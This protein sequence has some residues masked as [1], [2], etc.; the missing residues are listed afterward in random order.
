MGDLAIA[1]S[2]PKILW[3]G[4]GEEDSRNSVAPGY[5][6]YKS[7]DGGL[8]WQSMGLEKTQHIGRIVI[9]PTNPD[10]VWCPRWAPSGAPTPSAVSTRRRW[11]QNLDAEQVHQRQSRVRR[12]RHGSARPDVLYA[13][14]WE[15]IR[16]PALSQS[17]GPGS[18]LWKTTDGGATWTEIKGGGFPSETMKGR[19]SWPSR[20]APRT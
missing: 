8:T 20:P 18:A 16:K 9:H 2:N 15:R 14:S 3:A 10:I 12:Y 6:I 1:P 19:I 7:V 13:A 5:G 17:G 4:T 11:R